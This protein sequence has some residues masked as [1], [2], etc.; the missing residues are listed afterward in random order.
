MIFTRICYS[1]SPL[2][3][4]YA[5]FWIPTPKDFTATGRKTIYSYNPNKRLTQVEMFKRTNKVR[6]V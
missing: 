5:V 4:S 2:I 3:A 6:F 1:V